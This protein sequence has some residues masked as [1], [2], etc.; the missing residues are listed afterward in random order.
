MITRI[1]IDGFKSLRDF[2]IDLEP[3]TVLIG[4]N[5]AGKSNILDALA[6]LSRLAT[7]PIGEAFKLGRGKSIDQ[8]SRRGGEV[9]ES[10][11]FAVEMLVHGVYPEQGIFG[12]S[13]FQSRFRYELT[14]KRR[15]LR[16]GVEQFVARDERLRAMRREDD[17]WADPHPDYAPYMVYMDGGE[18]YFPSIKDEHSE[19]HWTV[20]HP[21]DRPEW[22]SLPSTHTA[23]GRTFSYASVFPSMI[24][25]SCFKDCRVLQLD[26]AQLGEPSERVDSGELAQDGSNLPTVLAEL[27]PTALGEIRADL[28]R[29]VPGIASFDVVPEG[30]EMRLDVELSGGER[31]PA[32]LISAG[33][34]RILALLT[35][36]RMGR[37]PSTLCVEEPENGI[38][39]GRLRALLDLFRDVA[40]Q[41]HEKEAQKSHSETLGLTHFTNQ[42]P[43]QILLT[44]HSPVALAALRAHPQHLRF[45][46]MVRRGGERITRVRA[47]GNPGAGDHGRLTISPREIDTLLQAA[48]AEE[49]T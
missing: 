8:F 15:A 21:L 36:L 3:F 11:R 28:A 22:A 34:L 2:A 5:S 45:V 12:R 38:Y 42:L 49:S 18:D 26:A 14:I 46:D 41:H 6:L 9:A 27:K 17:T 44:T 20:G 37:R 1:E 25:A 31:L 48:P 35:A 10:I 43:T 7:Y 23:L 33:T 39:P 24:V 16:A 30:D 13:G 40:I 32:R 29:L 19:E 47:V 4:P